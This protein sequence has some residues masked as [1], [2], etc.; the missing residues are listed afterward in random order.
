M[1]FIYIGLITFGAYVIYRE[2]DLAEFE[3]EIFNKIKEA[4][5]K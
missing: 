3:R 5:K 4:V 1:L 2:N